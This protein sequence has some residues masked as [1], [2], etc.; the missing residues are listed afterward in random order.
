MTTINLIKIPVSLTNLARW[1]GE[2]GKPV[3]FDSSVYDKGRV[4][5]HL[6]TET[7]GTE[8][9]KC[10]RLMASARATNANLYSY[11][12]LEA[13]DL[14]TNSTMYGMPEHLSVFGIDTI[15]GKPMPE[16]WRKDQLVGFDIRIRPVRRIIKELNLGNDVVKSGTE[17][18]AFLIEAKRSIPNSS[19]SM[20]ERGRTRQAVYL[21]W[22]IERTSDFA[23]IDRNNTRLNNFIRS[24]ILRGKKTIEGPDAIMH[25]N[26]KITDPLKFTHFLEKGIGRHR[27]FGYGMILLR[28]P[29]SPVPKY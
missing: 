19:S 29:N 8:A 28:P 24:K 17:L 10:F 22:L 15:Q 1:A 20:K 26:L 25:G 27:S 9:F 18:D 21:D 2:R 4:L 13:K 3:G 23:E 7:F 14:Q 12:C 6:M 16:N 5:H 11:S